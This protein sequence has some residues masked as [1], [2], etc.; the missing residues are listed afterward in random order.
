MTKIDITPDVT[1]IKKAG[2]VN[3]K[4]PQALAEL[5]D[6]PIDARTGGN[7][8]NVEVTLGQK[9]KQKRIAVQDDACGMTWEQASKAMVM[10]YSDKGGDAIG[11]F[12][13][14]LKTACSFLG[15]RFEIV[16]ATTDADKATRLVY[17]E[18]QFIESGAWEIDVEEV[19]KPFDHGT[20][21][22]IERLKVNLYPGVKDAVLRNFGKTFKHFVEAGEV[23][24]V[25]NG[26]SVVPHVTDTVADYDTPLHFDVDGKVV[27]GWVSLAPKG[28]G[29]GRYGFDLVRHNRVLAEHQKVGFK[30]GSGTSRIV[31]E[32][33]LDDFPVVNNKTDFRR[34]TEAW[35]GLQEQLKELLVD[36]VREAR[37]QANP[38]G[39]LDAK[40]KTEIKEHV[41]KVREALKTDALLG[42]LDRR[43][44]DSELG[45]EFGDGPLPFQLPSDGEEQSDG[46]AQQSSEG[47]AATGAAAGSGG[48]SG[49][50]RGGSGSM[51]RH[52]LNRVKTQLRNL[53]IEHDVARLGKGS[54]YKIWEAQGVG[55]RKKLVVTTNSDHPMYMAMQDSFMLWMKHNIVESV[56]E[57]FTEQTG[58]TEAMLLVKSDILKHVSKMQLAEDED[59][60]GLAPEE[61]AA[62]GA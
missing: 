24:I 6:N 53:A 28:S 60:S 15:S 39:Q 17:D 34:D 23:D 61:E 55:A 51:Q 49:A 42:D 31:G 20:R 8:L 33:H 52:R 45:D 2:E 22:E 5:V 54:L 62:A 44:L 19:E 38:G 7:K 35:H 11:E 16:T 10:A 12:G 30:A 59:D 43:A 36:S 4:I 3:Y 47:D 40:D 58:D 56:A 29:R 26:D 13:L 27:K 46:G 57:F 48:A 37:R 18:E 25:V 50:A 32:L 1:L 9:G 21:I 14:G 41:D